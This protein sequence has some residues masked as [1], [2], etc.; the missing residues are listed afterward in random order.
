MADKSAILRAKAAALELSAETVSE[1][2]ISGDFSLDGVDYYDIPHVYR[3]LF[4][5]SYGEGSSV[6]HEIWLPERWNGKFL[7]LGNGGIAGRIMH[8]YVPHGSF[9]NAV[10]EGYAAIMTDMGTENGRERG[11]NN[12]ELLRDFG[13]RATVKMTEL[14]KLVTEAFYGEGI[15]RSYFWGGSTGGQQALTTAQKCPLDYD[16]IIA[17]VPV[18]SRT[19]LHTYFAWNNAQIKK[20]GVRFSPETADKISRLAASFAI[21]EGMSDKGDVFVS[22]PRDDEG[23]ISRFIAFLSKHM[24]ELSEAQLSVLKEIYLGPRNPRTNERINAGM[25]IGAE[26][27]GG[28]L[29]ESQGEEP[30]EQYPFLWA[31]G[32]S[33]SALDFDFDKD[34]CALTER[35]SPDLDAMDADL[36][37]FFSHGGKLLMFSTSG[38]GCVPPLEARRYYESVCAA[39]GKEKTL[40]HARYFLVPGQDHSVSLTRHGD[41][42]VNEKHKMQRDIC[43]LS[44]WVENGIVPASLTLATERYGVR[45]EKTIF[46]YEMDKH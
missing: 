43:V 3:F 5:A 23:T 20:N 7:G 2:A 30:F 38:D 13:W 21:G 28:G 46:A 19:R 9:A 40:E 35:L 41:V 11:I 10:A 15:K 14:G 45:I 24:K 44:N 1:G 29:R 18:T 26:A 42:T 12:P 8:G 27:L 33:F 39:V 4:H 6:Y 34:M 16:G 37:P 25:P 36:S 22:R 17:A 32:K 31:F